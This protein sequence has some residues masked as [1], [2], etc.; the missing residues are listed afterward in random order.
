MPATIA[1]EPKDLLN[2][3]KEA[4]FLRVYLV[5][6]YK[7]NKQSSFVLNVNAE[8]GFGKTYFLENLTKDLKAEKHPVIYFDAWKNDFTDNPLL[9]FIS[10]L[11]TS[12]EPF[13]SRSVPAKKLLKN[14]YNVSKQIFFPVLMKKALGYGIEE[15]TELLAE[16]DATESNPTEQNTTETNDNAELVDNVSSVISRV[17][18]LALK[19]HNGVKTSIETFKVQMQKLLNHIDLNLKSNELPMFVLIDELDRCRPSYAIE[20]L[21]NIK[22]IFEIPGIVF[23]IATDSKQL[24]HS[25]NAVYGNDFAS[26]RYLKRFFN[27]EY[28]LAKPDNYSYANYLFDNYGLSDNQ[29]LF[30]PLNISFYQEQNLLVTLFSGYADFFKLSLRDQEQTV[31]MLSSITLVWNSNEPIHLGYLL[32]LIMLKQKSNDMFTTLNETP[33]SKRDELLTPNF[34]SKVDTDMTVSFKDY[35]NMSSQR[36]EE[37]Q[38]G[39]I[40]LVKIYLG[41]V[42]MT[43]D[44]FQRKQNNENIRSNLEITVLRKFGNSMQGF[45]N[46]TVLVDKNLQTYPELVLRAGQFS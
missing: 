36:S 25:I 15:I 27:Q 16:K 45:V 11:N 32:F 17:A 24:A 39:I 37:V 22:H 34:F 33:L 41:L 29:K 10:E 3:Q 2:R 31:I 28:N 12:L 44:Q 8:W 20:L 40:S 13:L 18:E 23:V 30:S 46:N 9:A 6:R 14:A 42:N 35:G 5:N 38:Y 1:W 19:E 43:Y 7:A 21:E 26:E 4:D